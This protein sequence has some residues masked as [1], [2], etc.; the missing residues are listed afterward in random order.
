MSRPSSMGAP[1]SSLAGGEGTVACLLTLLERGCIEQQ[2]EITR[3]AVP[4]S[5]SFD[6][7]S[8]IELASAAKI[9]RF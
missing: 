3:M 9:T 5:C 7:V 4:C 2:P 1:S 8:R 6:S